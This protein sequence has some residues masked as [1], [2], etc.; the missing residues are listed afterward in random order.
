MSDQP[1]FLTKNDDLSEARPE[2]DLLHPA[3]NGK[4]SGDSLTETQYFGFSVPEHGIH[5]LAY[6][7][8]H[9]NLKVVTGGVMAWK[10]IARRSIDAEL[11]DI[12]AYM[13]D[14]A[15]AN[16]LHD[17]RL[18]NGYGVRIIEPN[19]A[20]EL[21]YS[22][23]A[24]Q[25][26]VTLRYDAVTPTIMFG[27]GTHLEQGLRVTGELTLLGTTY[28]VDCFNIRDRSWAKLRPENSM[29]LPPISWL[30]GVFGKDLFFNCNIMD[31]EGSN[32]FCTGTFSKSPADA[33]T[34]GW[35]WDKGEL[36]RVVQAFKTVERDPHDLLPRRMTLHLITSSGRELKIDGELVASCP[37]ATWPNMLANVTLMRWTCEG[38]TGYGDC[39]DVLWSDFARHCAAFSQA[40]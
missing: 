16:D 31:H 3:A 38:Q 39:Q 40:G 27:D 36:S 29:P 23:E 14:A 26:R 1:F 5:G 37:W 13:S 34:S 9:P 25:N 20:F 24:K 22:D 18:D 19:K 7:W 15:I 10:G 6:L 33:L 12:R 8:H 35:V 21:T 2:D 32:P 11:F 4:V 30:S 17:F 28:A